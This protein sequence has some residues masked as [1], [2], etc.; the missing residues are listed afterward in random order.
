MDSE[1]RHHFPALLPF[2]LMMSTPIKSGTSNLSRLPS[3]SAWCSL[4]RHASYFPLM[5][6]ANETA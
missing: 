1:A 2:T 6:L 5:R 3:G 4:A